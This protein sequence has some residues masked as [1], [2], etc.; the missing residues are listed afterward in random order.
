MLYPVGLVSLAFQGGAAFSAVGAS[1]LGPSAVAGRS[2]VA[3]AAMESKWEMKEITPDGK[4]VQRVEGNTTVLTAVLRFRCMLGAHLLWRVHAGRQ[5]LRTRLPALRSPV[6]A[7]PDILM[8]CTNQPRCQLIWQRPGLL[9][10]QDE[11]RDVYHAPTPPAGTGSHASS[12]A[13]F[14]T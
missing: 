6:P 1:K 5:R 8:D 12:S 7:R 3:P 9:P 14:P 4:L 10:A 11:F 13:A 2:R